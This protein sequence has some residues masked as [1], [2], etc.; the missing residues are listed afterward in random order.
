MI[1]DLSH[2]CHL[3]PQKHHLNF[4]RFFFFFLGGEGCCVLTC[5]GQFLTYH[6]FTDLLNNSGSEMTSIQ[7]EII[8]IWKLHVFQKTV[9]ILWH[10]TTNY[11]W[12]HNKYAVS[13]QR[14]NNK[15]SHLKRHFV[16]KDSLYT[17]TIKQ[18][19]TTRN[20]SLA[21]FKTLTGWNSDVQIT[22]CSSET[23]CTRKRM[24]L[25][26]P[27]PTEQVDIVTG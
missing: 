13:L 9:A 16:T 22:Q 23:D 8:N 11:K 6:W 18:Q 24:S 2:E 14:F 25:C 21:T 4:T 7:N 15:T 3:A 27:L 1:S 19:H 26:N 17:I 10:N 20:H 12:Y 5:M